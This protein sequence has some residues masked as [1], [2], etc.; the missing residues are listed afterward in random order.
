VKAVLTVIGLAFLA[1]S[2][3]L[4]TAVATSP[5][6]TAGSPH[7]T[8]SAV[9]SSRTLENDSP[10]RQ[11]A[12]E[13]LHTRFI[14]FQSKRFTVFTDCGAEVA[15]RQLSL[16]ERT[17]HQ[18]H[19][20]CNRI[21]LQPLPLKHKL[22]CV[23]F[24]SMADFQHF[25]KTHDNVIDNR[26][27]G[28]YS[29][30]HDWIVFYHADGSHEVV[31]AQ[32]D[33]Q[34]LWSDTDALAEQASQAALDGR[35]QDAQSIRTAVRRSRAQIDQHRKEV[36]EYSQQRNIATTVHEAVHQLLF[37]TGVQSANVQYPLWICEGLATSFETDAPHQTFGPDA[38]YLPRR[39]RPRPFSRS[40]NSCNL[41][42]FQMSIPTSCISRAT[43]L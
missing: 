16:L 17:H 41:K 3:F 32:H 25:G 31:R 29:P 14:E 27:S 11:L 36:A 2:C 8:R 10:A 35:H 19:R 39:Q 4:R 7:E 15:G 34:E 43:R 18:Y 37:H 12:R 5:Q 38:E 28:Y 33:L 42:P 26:I 40:R 30:R 6:D 1:L 23:L 21:R 13:S 9:A 24:S 20:F 22:V